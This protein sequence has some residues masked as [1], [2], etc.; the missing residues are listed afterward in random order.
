MKKIF[1]MCL[2]SIA[3]ISIQAQEKVKGGKSEKPKKTE[4]AETSDKPVK[5]RPDAATRATKL[6]N[7]MEKQLLL[8]AEQKPKVYDINLKAAKKVDEAHA[9]FGSDKKALGMQRKTIEAQRDA[10]LKTVLTAP[11]YDKWIKLKA[12]KKKKIKE[13]KDKDG[14]GKTK[15][16]DAG[17]T[18]AIPTDDIND[19]DVI[20]E[21][22]SDR[23]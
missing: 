14:K 4:T 22:E 9:Q 7:R 10:E 17:G 18:G 23:E 1:L 2:L 20:D 12:E 13:K 16:K 11:Q 19:S 21:I 3:V 6:T 8:T 15:P 5:Q